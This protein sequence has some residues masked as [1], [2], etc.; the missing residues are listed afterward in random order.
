MGRVP[1]KVVVDFFFDVVSPYSYIAFELLQRCNVKWENMDLKLKPVFLGGIMAATGNQG[2]A[3]LPIRAQYMNKD[4][5]RLAEYYNMPFQFNAHIQKLFFQKGTLPT[6]RVLGVVKKDYPDILESL[7][8]DMFRRVWADNED[9]TC[10]G[11]LKTACQKAGLTDTARDEVLSAS[12][13]DTGKQ[14]LKNLT[15]Q[16]LDFGAFGVPTYVAHLDDG[17]KMIFGS[18]R[19]FL[20]ASYLGHE[21]TATRN[22]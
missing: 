9:I 2:P 20:L 7:S 4:L 15:Q 19:L 11:I 10:D 14:E 8:S 1:K 12:I 16:A 22:D 5:P 17:P 6:Q 3:M 13:S 21:W 18:D